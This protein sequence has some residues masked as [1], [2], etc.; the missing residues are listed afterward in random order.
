[1]IHLASRIWINLGARL[2][3]ALSSGAETSVSLFGENP[4]IVECDND[5]HRSLVDFGNKP[6]DVSSECSRRSTTLT[7]IA[8]PM[9][10]PI[11]AGEHVGSIEEGLMP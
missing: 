5:A 2:A 3:V 11:S 4:R 7:D 1:M 8:L 9:S 10:L 6:T